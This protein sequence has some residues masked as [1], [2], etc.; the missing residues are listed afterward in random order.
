MNTTEIDADV[1]YA[2]SYPQRSG[3]YPRGYSPSARYRG[4]QRGYPP[5]A[6]DRK[7]YTK[8]ETKSVPANE[9]M[10]S[11]SGHQ[12]GHCETGDVSNGI[13]GFIV[14][15]IVLFIIVLLVLWACKPRFCLKN[16]S[17]CDCDIGKLILT[18]AFIAFVI[19]IIIWLIK[20]VA[21]SSKKMC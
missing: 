20:V 3:A 8:C 2:S 9:S 7:I 12:D 14:L 18:A 16:D 17:E 1:H 6:D 21:C 15:F 13:A 4:A 10:M 5:C 19:I 11:H